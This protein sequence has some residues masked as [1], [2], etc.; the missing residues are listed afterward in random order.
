V[1]SNP[2]PQNE[3]FAP[4][5]D[6]VFAWVI[7]PVQDISGWTLEFH[8]RNK[9]N[10]LLLSRAGVLTDPVNGAATF[11]FTSSETGTTLGF[12]DFDYDVWRIDAGFAKQLTYGELN[13]RGQQ[14]Q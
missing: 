4:F 1:S 8:V 9:D 2:N 3:S 13:A 6:I 11:T 7:T 12:D 14:W 10:T 5:E